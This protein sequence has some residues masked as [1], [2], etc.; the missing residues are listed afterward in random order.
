MFPVC[1]A[2]KKDF[3][4]ICVSSD[5]ITFRFSNR[6]RMFP[7]AHGREGVV[8][9][10]RNVADE[11][12][13]SVGDFQA[14][15]RAVHQAVGFKRRERRE[16]RRKVFREV[17]AELLRHRGVIEREIAHHAHDGFAAD[18]VLVGQEICALER[19]PAGVHGRL[20]FRQFLLV[21]AQ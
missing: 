9:A 2:L 13:A 8:E 12:A 19:H 7:L 16:F 3:S 21:L 15:W 17:E 6:P 1:K 10:H 18:F 11:Q 4:F 14:G 20:P 5:V